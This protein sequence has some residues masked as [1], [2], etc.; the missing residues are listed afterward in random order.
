MAISQENAWTLANSAMTR[1]TLRRMSSVSVGDSLA[2]STDATDALLPVGDWAAGAESASIVRHMATTVE[3]TTG[4]LYPPSKKNAIRL[5]MM[6]G[7]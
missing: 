1:D 5:P 2:L 4:G 3:A 7:L 6:L